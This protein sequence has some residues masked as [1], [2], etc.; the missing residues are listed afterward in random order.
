MVEAAPDPLPD[1]QDFHRIMATFSKIGGTPAGGVTRLAGSEADGHAR[2]E[3]VS[4]LKASGASISVDRVGN[5]FGLFDLG[6]S[7]SDCI[8]CGSHLDSQPRGGRFDGAYGVAAAV[9]AAKAVLQNSQQNPGTKPRRNLAVVNWTNEEGARFQ[10]S[11][12]GSSCYAGRLS[13]ETALSVRDG[14]GVLLADALKAIGYDGRQNFA[15]RPVRYVELHIEQGEKLEKAG[16]RVGTV[17]GCWA[18]RKIRLRFIGQTAHTGPTPMNQRRD[19]LHAACRAVVA[20]HDIADGF[21]GELHVSAGRMEIAP[22]SPNVVAGH[23]DVWFEFRAPNNDD[24]DRAVDQFHASLA[25]IAKRLLVQHEIVDETLRPSE[26]LPVDGVHLV[27]SVAESLRL[28]SMRLRTIAG[29]D[30]IAISAFVPS[31]LLFVPSIGGISHSEAELTSQSDLEAGLATL[32]G[33]LWR[34]VTD[35]AQD[36][37]IVH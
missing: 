3:F 7:Q 12:L 34:L 2:D 8:L 22:N 13:P 11:L 25:K 21:Q 30:A 18:T 16:M 33:V 28:S 20:L 32:T 24:C 4:L 26:D 29:H 9:I 5:I 27:E 31:I 17:M 37:A 15:P 6:G 36:A 14:D 1:Y 35:P 23:V 19:A 10:P